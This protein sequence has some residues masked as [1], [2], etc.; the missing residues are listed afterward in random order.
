VYSQYNFDRTGDTQAQP[1]WVPQSYTFVASSSATTLSFVS[2]T[3][4]ACGPAIDDV[5]AVDV[6]PAAMCADWT[7]ADSDTTIGYFCS[8]NGGGF[9]MCLSGAFAPQSTYLNC[10]AGTSCNCPVGTECSQHGTVAPC[11]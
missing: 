5:S 6:S 8:A 9:Y 2:V 11:S 3:P 4:G 1:G 7:W 10:A